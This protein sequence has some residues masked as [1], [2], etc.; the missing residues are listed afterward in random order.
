MG[1][2]LRVTRVYFVKDV[3]VCVL[4]GLVRV[5]T[6]TLGLGF[7]RF[8]TFLASPAM[9]PCSWGEKLKGRLSAGEGSAVS[10]TPWF[11]ME[12]SACYPAVFC[13]IFRLFC[14]V[15]CARHVSSTLSSLPGADAYFEGASALLEKNG[16]PVHLDMYRKCFGSLE[17]P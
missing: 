15:S 11:R 16:M 7:P 13:T 4:S 10:Q 9:L 17:S 5:A 14:C 6:D 3:G 12:S 8:L 2:L 1:E